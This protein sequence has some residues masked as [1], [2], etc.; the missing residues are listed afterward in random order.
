MDVLCH[1]WVVIGRPED[2]AR[3]GS[4]RELQIGKDIDTLHSGTDHTPGIKSLHCHLQGFNN[5]I[6]ERHNRV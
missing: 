3:T 1:Q 2:R 4:P 6:C 5:K